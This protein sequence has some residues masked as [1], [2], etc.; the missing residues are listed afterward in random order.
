MK[1]FNYIKNIERA[2]LALSSSFLAFL[3]GCSDTINRTMAAYGMPH[4]TF[5]ISGVIRTAESNEPVEGLEVTLNNIDGDYQEKPVLT[6][7]QGEYRCST[8]VYP[9]DGSI[10]LRV[11]DI[12]GETNGLFDFKDTTVNYA[13]S[14][15]SGGDGEWNAGDINR[16]LDLLMKESN[17]NTNQ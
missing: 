16:E 17:E 3:L 7:E 4:A 9:A 15:I 8:T 12:D 10:E 14:E 5:K 11:K 2:A 13:E 6:N 1:R